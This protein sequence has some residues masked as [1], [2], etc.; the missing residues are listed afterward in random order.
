[1]LG[2]GWFPLENPECEPIPSQ[3][4]AGGTFF[5]WPPAALRDDS[6]QAGRTGWLAARRSLP[7]D[8]DLSE[9]GYLAELGSTKVES[10]SSLPG[11]TGASSWLTGGPASP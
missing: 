9:P 3:M 5:G 8:S 6:G 10:S 1:M 2:W 7:V 11:L 4:A